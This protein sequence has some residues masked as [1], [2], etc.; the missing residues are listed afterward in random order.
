MEITRDG[1]PCALCHT[2][3]T[4]LGYLVL[5]APFSFPQREVIKDR[6]CPTGCH[7]LQS[8]RWKKAMPLAAGDDA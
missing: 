8:A 3:T 7:Q 6:W 4:Q 1:I 2:V 5:S